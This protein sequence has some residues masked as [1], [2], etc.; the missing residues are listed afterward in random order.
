MMVNRGI[1]MWLYPDLNGDPV[2]AMPGMPGMHRFD[3]LDRGASFADAACHPGDRAE[4]MTLKQ[5]K[6]TETWGNP[7]KHGEILVGNI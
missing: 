2:P 3:P 6:S 5:G 4:W 1:F 7:L